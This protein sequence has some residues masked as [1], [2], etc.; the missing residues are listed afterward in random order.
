MSPDPYL[1]ARPRA[2]A[3][4]HRVLDA[5]ATF[6]ERFVAFPVPEQRDAVT[7]WTFHAHAIACADATARLA[8]QSAEKQSGKTPLLEVLE[9][10]V[11]APLLVASTSTAALFRTIDV[12]PTTILMDEVDAVLGPH[13][14]GQGEELRALLNAGYRRGATVARVVGSAAP[15]S[16]LNQK[17]CSCLMSHST[18]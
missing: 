12:G 3:K 10:L 9:L 7:L 11:P 16:V 17:R 2:G 4:P 15:G 5:A 6:I 13:I 14:K 1:R 18:R 8:V